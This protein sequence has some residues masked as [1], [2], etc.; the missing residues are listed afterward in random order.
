MTDYWN[1]WGLLLSVALFLGAV[2]FQ[3]N[4]A[5][6]MS[7]ICVLQSSPNDQ[8][9]DRIV[10]TQTNRGVRLKGAIRNLK[11]GSHQVHVPVVAHVGDIEANC[12]GLADVDLLIQGREIQELIGCEI[13]LCDEDTMQAMLRGECEC[14]SCDQSSPPAVTGIVELTDS[15][16]DGDAQDI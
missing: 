8:A 2:N 7:A 9:G 14:H 1:D 5:T 16:L 15:K 13:V 4:S 3:A 11:P 6:P 12:D 10:L